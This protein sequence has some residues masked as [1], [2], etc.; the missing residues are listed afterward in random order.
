MRWIQVCLAAGFLALAEST[1]GPTPTI[2]AQQ[3]SC[4]HATDESPEQAARR[5]Q[6]LG[7]TREINTLQAQR[8]T[9]TCRSIGSP[10]TASA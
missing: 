5:K 2:A 9:S 3:G 4:L 7:L 6:A 1:T 8:L 10:H